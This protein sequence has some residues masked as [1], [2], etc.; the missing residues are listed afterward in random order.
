MV[1]VLLVAIAINFVL[2]LFPTFA[3]AAVDCSTWCRTNRCMPGNAFGN[4]QQRCVDACEA[5]Q[6]SKK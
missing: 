3:Q 4:C 6:K 5:K 1:R 2:G